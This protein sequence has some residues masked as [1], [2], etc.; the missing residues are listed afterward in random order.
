MSKLYFENLDELGSLTLK[1]ILYFFE[2]P[3]IFTLL[4]ISE[5]KRYLCLCSEI[6]F[7]RK[8]ILTRISDE[9]LNKMIQNEITICEAFEREKENIYIVQYFKEGYKVKTCSYNELDPLDL[10]KTTERLDI[11]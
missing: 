1:N 6:R 2:E 8:W 10:P 5:H 3:I 11:M 9:I 7:E 4:S